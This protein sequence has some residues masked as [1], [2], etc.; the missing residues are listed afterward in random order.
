MHDAQELKTCISAL[1]A[2][3][4]YIAYFHRRRHLQL[5]PRQRIYC[6]AECQKI[7]W[8]SHKLECGMPY[9]TFLR[10]DDLI[11]PHSCQGKRIGSTSQVSI[12]SSRVSPSNATTIDP[13]TPLS[14]TPSWIRQSCT[15]FVTPQW[16]CWATSSLHLKEGLKN[17]GPVLPHPRC[18][19]TCTIE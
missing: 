3:R 16:S 5:I 11:A 17:G 4:Y 6:S 1:R 2:V 19:P 8:P 18:D 13:P 15:V 14:Y 12:R 9:T 10:D 7:D